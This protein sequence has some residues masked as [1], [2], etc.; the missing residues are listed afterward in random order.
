MRL[1][2]GVRRMEVRRD[3]TT[4]PIRRTRRL[5]FDEGLNV[6]DVVSLLLA[7]LDLRVHAVLRSAHQ[8]RTT[9]RYEILTYGP[10][11]QN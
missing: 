10:G 3:T 9:V 6:L 7:Q 11:I 4:E 5:Q 2:L 1:N 8:S